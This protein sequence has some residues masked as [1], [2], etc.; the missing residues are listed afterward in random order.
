MTDPTSLADLRPDPANARRHTP[1]NVGTIVDA[2]HAVGAARSIVVDEDGVILAGNAT[3]QAAAEA[4][5]HRVQV[6]EAD[7][8]TLIAVRRSGLTPAQKRRLALADNRA[9][10]L[11]EWDPAQ[12]AAFLEEDATAL[13]GLFHD[14]ELARLLGDP[15]P[16]TLPDPGPR[17]DLTAEL[18]E[19]WATEE[20]QL[21]TIGRHRLLCGDA[22]DPSAV[23]RLF[24]GATPRLMITDPPYGMGYDPAWREARGLNEYPGRRRRPIPTGDDAPTDWTAAFAPPCLEVAYCWAP[25]GA[26]QFLTQRMLEAAGYE[27]RQ[28]IVWVKPVAP[29]SRSAYHWRHEPCWYAVRRGATAGWIGDRTQTTVW[30][31]SSPIQVGTPS[32]EQSSVHPTQKPLDCYAIPLRNHA[33]DLYDPFVGSGTALVAAEQAGRACYALEIDP[34]Y[35]AVCLER[36]A[37]M[38]LDVRRG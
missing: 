20:S 2:L 38:G 35:V 6:V 5:I 25:P 8:N 13:E 12:L 31:M 23:A 1:R 34:G 9:A 37:G 11:A 19:R 17:P 3:V 22:T 32:S 30:E 10:E 21:W 16:A 33:G 14:D 24:E 28:Q 29:I 26:Q 15:A 18:R 7:G 4:G 27:V 36:L